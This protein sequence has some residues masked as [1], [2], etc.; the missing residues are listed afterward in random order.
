MR[1]A[2][3]R[4]LVA[5]EKPL[6]RQEFIELLNGDGY[7]VLALEDA[8]SSLP[9]VRDF[10]AHLFVVDLAQ[11]AVVQSEVFRYQYGRALPA[12]MLVASS[13]RASA[14]AQ[15]LR[16]DAFVP[17]PFLP[18]SFL[19]AVG[20]LCGSPTRPAELVVVQRGERRST[21]RPSAGNIKPCL[22]CGFAM[23]FEENPTAPPVWL[24]RNEGCRNEE[25]VRARRADA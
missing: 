11:A 25:F 14:L 1:M 6:L 7:E 10:G 12:M 24:C 17:Y 22:R 4:V 13:P 2:M 20:G 16:A 19:S 5:L 21:S 23:R 15:R 9:R 8:G 18:D 3:P